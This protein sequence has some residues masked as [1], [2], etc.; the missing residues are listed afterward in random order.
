MKRPALNFI[1][2]ALAFVQFAFLTT[3]GV[4]MHFIL[5]PGSG[6]RQ[7]IWSLD[8]HEWGEIHLWIAF[9][10]LATLAL[11][12]LLHWRWIVC[13]VQGRQTSSSGLR[14]GLGVLGLVA[15]VGLAAAPLYGDVETS[16]DGSGQGRGKGAPQ[17]RLLPQH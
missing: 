17:Q 16:P 14:L 11:H 5:P 4:L 6:H 9:A 8:R 15:A 13:T 7:S 3:T 1:I 10:L 2:D 12:L